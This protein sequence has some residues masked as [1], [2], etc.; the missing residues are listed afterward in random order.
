MARRDEDEELENDEYVAPA[1][2]ASRKRMHESYRIMQ[3][4]DVELQGGNQDAFIT[5][6]DFQFGFLS[7][8]IEP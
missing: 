2:L 8:I 6:S 5:V 4:N 1:G 3:Q 7:P